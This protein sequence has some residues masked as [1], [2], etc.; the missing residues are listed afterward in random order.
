[1]YLISKIQSKKK[2]HKA[3]RI[4]VFLP[5]LFGDR[6][7][8]ILI[9]IRIHTSDWRIRIRIQEA[10]KHVDPG[11]PIRIRIQIRNTAAD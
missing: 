6:R 7:I 2:S 10:Q 1:M 4:N 5:F 9:Q 8:Q 11:D 3:V